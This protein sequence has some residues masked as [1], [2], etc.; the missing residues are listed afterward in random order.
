MPVARPRPCLYPG[1]AA[2]VRNGGYCERHAVAQQERAR[3]KDRE[4][5]SAAS[6][7]YGYRWA[8]TS[9]GF[10]RN[11]PLCRHCADRGRVT[12]AEVTDHIVPHRLAEALASGEPE[13]I[14]EARSLFWDRSNW[15]PLCW[16]CHSR[17]TA[18]EDGAFG[19]RRALAGGSMQT[20]ATDPRAKGARRGARDTG[21]GRG[22]VGGSKV[23]ANGVGTERPAEFLWERFE[24]GGGGVK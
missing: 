1:C 13:R 23:G 20:S 21:T 3:E 6:R 11:N 7:G 2:L 17:K 19:N 22:G 10:L 4:R 24:K 9:Q 12:A 5:G 18:R 15:Q 14:V 16:T 8:K